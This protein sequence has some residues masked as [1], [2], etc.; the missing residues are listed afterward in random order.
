MQCDSYNADTIFLKKKKKKTK[1]KKSEI[2]LHLND[3]ETTA[4]QIPLLYSCTG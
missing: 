3:I 2:H 4:A 1:T